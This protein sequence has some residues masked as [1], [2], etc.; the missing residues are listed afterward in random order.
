MSSS[1]VGAAAINVVTGFRGFRPSLLGKINTTVQI[2]AIGIIMLAASIPYG[3]GW[4]LPTIYATVFCV[5]RTL[6]RPLRL[7][8]LQTRQ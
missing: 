2:V 4:Y 7:F 3:T 6:G 8:R 5:R 1:L